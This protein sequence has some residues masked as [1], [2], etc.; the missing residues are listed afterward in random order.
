MPSECRDVPHPEHGG[1][2]LEAHGEAEVVDTRVDWQ[3]PG[4]E[5][6]YDED[7]CFGGVRS[8]VVEEGGIAGGDVLHEHEDE[9]GLG[10]AH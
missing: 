1:R 3:S 9:F 4:R 8:E 2:L 5:G 6:S 7:F 10:N